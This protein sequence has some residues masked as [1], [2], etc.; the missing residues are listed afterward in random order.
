M[1]PFIKYLEAR[2]TPPNEERGWIRKAARYTLIGGELFRRGFSKPLLKC[3]TREKADYVIQE[4]HQGICGYHSGP[5]TMAARILRAG[6]YWPTIEED[7]TT[8][9]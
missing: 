9:R 8:D 3:I 6:Y 1:E 4:I 7:C 2:V 5:K